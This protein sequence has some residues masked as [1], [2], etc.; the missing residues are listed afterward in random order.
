MPKLTSSTMAVAF[1]AMQAFASTASA[2]CIEGGD[3]TNPTLTCTATDSGNI[4][5]SRDKLSVSVENDAQ[6]VR[7][8]GR[9]VQLEGSDQSIINRGL[10]ESDDDDAIRGKGENLTVD[11]YGTIRGG[12]RGIR[13]QDDAN[14]FTLINRESGQIF[15][16]NQ[17]VRLDNGDALENATITNYGLIKSQDGRAIQS[18]GPGGKV[19]N[20]GTLLGGEEVIEAREDFYLE[21]HGTI[22]IHG[23]EWNANTQT[24]TKDDAVATPDQDGVQFASG[25]VHNHGLILSTDDGIDLDEGRVH[26]YASGV[27]V[28]AGPNNDPSKGGIDID[29]QFEPTVGADRPAGP[30]FIINEGYIEGGRAI[31]TD[32]FSTAEITIEN[33][34]TLLGRSGTA[35]G[36]AAGQGNSTLLVNG[37]S[38]IIGD[39]IFGAGDDV[40]KLNSGRI[41]GNVEFGAGDDL[42]EVRGGHLAGNVDWGTGT[43]TL[44]V[45]DAEVGVLNFVSAPE[46]LDMSSAPDYALFAGLTLAVADPQAFAAMDDLA[47]QINYGLAD[48]VLQPTFGSGWWIKGNARVDEDDRTNGTLAVGRDFGNV[49]LYLVHNRGENDALHQVDQQATAI[50]LRSGWAASDNTRVSATLFAGVSDNRID[51][52]D[53]ATGSGDT[54]GHFV[55]LSARVDH[56]RPASSD[57]MG[58][59]LSAQLGMTRFSNDAFTVSGLSGARFG[60]R[61]LTTGFLSTEAALPMKLS[62][63]MELRPFIGAHALFT[64]ADQVTMSLPGGSTSFATDGDK[65]VTGLRLGTELHLSRSLA[66]WSLRLETQIDED[67]TAALALGALINF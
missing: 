17:A 3:A 30:V 40:L 33:S 59:L 32:E 39:V 60:S 27:I 38:N 52:P 45:L 29:A 57:A 4:D 54:D 26:N 19:F 36:L 65:T 12:D 48:T 7:I 43:N 22:A 34:G 56:T 11:N 35:I 2:S 62:N 25:E 63:G 46:V 47:T 41:N 42:L 5:D 53:W 16:V 44:R 67:G 49:G 23:L 55:G 61:D 15:A 18:R 31:A 64:D 10:I 13:L 9:P 58:S 24:W 8:G 50:G 51:S 20:Y 21:N 28:S 1:V 6:L 14:G 66:P 37:N